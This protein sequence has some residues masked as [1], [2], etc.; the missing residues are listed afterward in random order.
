MSPRIGHAL[1]ADVVP[2][3]ARC[4]PAMGYAVAGLQGRPAVVLVVAAG[5]DIEPVER[6]LGVA[7]P[8]ALEGCDY[9]LVAL[10]LARAQALADALAPDVAP[11]LR[12]P[13]GVGQCWCLVLR[14]PVGSLTVPVTPVTAPRVR[15]RA[16]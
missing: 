16:N 3:L 15:G 7:L 14:A 1:P 4:I 10:P 9:V 13:V 12:E 8:P 6:E 11:S 2:V 5:R